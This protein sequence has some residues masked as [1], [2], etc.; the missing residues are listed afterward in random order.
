MF[1]FKLGSHFPSQTTLSNILPSK[2]TFLTQNT[3]AAK[4]KKQSIKLSWGQR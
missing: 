2:T 3:L 1:M 4:H